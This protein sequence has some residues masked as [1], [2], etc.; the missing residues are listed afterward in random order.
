MCPL[1][2]S[3]PAFNARVVFVAWLLGPWVKVQV[4]VGKVSYPKSDLRMNG[5][6][7]NG[8]PFFFLEKLMKTGITKMIVYRNSLCFFFN[9]KAPGIVDSFLASIFV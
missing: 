7:F 2:G 4:S 9:F 8:N 5:N 3:S 1:I 6:F